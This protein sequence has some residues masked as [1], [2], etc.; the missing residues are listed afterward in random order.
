VETLPDGNQ[1]LAWSPGACG[2]TARPFGSGP[3]RPCRTA[4]DGAHEGKADRPPSRA[5]SA[6]RPWPIRHWRQKGNK[7]DASIFLCAGA[8]GGTARTRPTPSATALVTTYSYNAAG[9]V[10]DVTDP[11]GLD[12]R[13]LYDALGRITET[14]DNYTGS[15]ETATS[16]VATQYTYDGDNHVLTV[17]ADEPSGS[18]QKTQYVYGVTTATGSNINSNDILAAVEHPDPTTGNPSTS[19][20]DK[21]TTNALGQV[22]SM[23]D[24]NGN[25]HQYTYDILGR[26]TSDA[27]TTLGSGVDG[28]IRRIQYAYDSQGNQY[29]VTSYNAATGGSIVNQMENV[30]NGLGQLTGQYQSHS[31]AVNT[32]TTPEVQYAYTEMSSGQNNNRLTSITYPSGYV[33]YYN[34]ASGLDSNISRLTSISDASGVLE[35]YKYLGLA[36]VV[37]RDHPQTDVNLTYISQTG[38]TGDAGDQYTGL[39]R[40]GRVVDQNWYDTATDT[41]TDNIEYGYDADSNVLY[42]QNAVDTA[43]SQLFTYDG[44]NQLASFQ[45]GTLNST[46]T[47]LVGSATD[48]QSFTPDALGNFTS[49]TTNG[50]TQT[51]TANQQNEITSISG[52]GTVTYDANGNTTADGIGNTLVYDAWN[53]LVRVVNA[54]ATVAAYGYNGLGERITETHGTTTTDLYYSSSWDVLEERVNGVIQARNVWSPAGVDTLVLRDQSSLDNGTLDQ[55]LY[56][57]TDAN[58]N[59]TALVDINGNVLERYTYDPYGNMTVWTPSWTARGMSLYGWMYYF[60][61]KRYD[62]IT[63]TYDSRDRVYSPTLRRPEQADPLG[64]VPGNNYYEW[65]GDRPVNAADPLGT[66]PFLTI[67]T[68]A[69]WSPSYN[70]MAPSQP[71]VPTP[72]H[73]L[74]L[75]AAGKK[76][77]IKPEVIEA[78]IRVSKKTWV[79]P[80]PSGLCEAYAEQVQINLSKELN[81]LDFWPL[82]DTG[83]T[84]NV[85]SWDDA[86]FWPWWDSHAAYKITFPDGSSFSL[87]NGA[88]N[89]LWQKITPGADIPG[90]LTHEK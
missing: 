19:Q 75:L 44:L 49:V 36:T 6:F 45:Q 90:W 10:Q 37:E 63:G 26:L 77:H 84:G 40:F 27:V 70:P 8:N 85:V 43:F 13:T 82:K 15:A 56:V 55:R 14:I 88:I 76:N 50:T 35:S 68:N 66:D 25:V 11:L 51:E 17:T 39:D 18:Y 34:Y 23:T 78:I 9:W 30:Y 42:Q 48:S 69:P 58:G 79:W 16:D 53:R 73:V 67:P 71:P 80:R 41:S 22:T 87:D 60:Q 21:Y 46:K 12:T 83:L 33:V 64:L 52:A 74:L 81:S 7:A 72:S 38:A 89:G 61:G 59:V 5:A 2:R 32:S 57:Q 65:E 20:E 86:S 29:L 31:G 4:P 3:L 1:N 28:A 54:G 47:G 62:P 24:R